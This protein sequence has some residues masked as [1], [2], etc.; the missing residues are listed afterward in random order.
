MKLNQSSI[1]WAMKH[2]FKESDTDLF[3]K[4]LEIKVIN[5]MHDK[6][7]DKLKDV[8]LGNYKWKA[9]RRFVIPKAEFSYR[10]VTQLDPIDSILFSAIVYEYGKFIESRRQ[11]INKVFSYRFSPSSDGTLY[12]NQTA[13]S[14]FWQT[15]LQKSK[16]FKYIVYL[17]IADFYNQIY[18]HVI[19]NQ[20][21][22]CGLPNQIIRSVINLL[23]SVTQTVSR[24]IPIG[25]HASHLIAEM[26]LIP[27]DESLVL[28]KIEFCRYADDIVIFCD[29]EMEAK[30]NIYTIAEILDKQQRLILQRQKTKIYTAEEF[31]RICD[32]MLK[33]NP[34]NKLEEKMIK[35]IL[36]HSSGDPYKHISMSN[37]T[38]EEKE[39]F[40][41][42]KI[43]A[44]ILEYLKEFEPNY[45]R[46]RWFYRRLTQIG[47]TH[48]IE[49]SIKNMEKLI[50]AISDVCHYL[51][52]AAGNY[53]K[54]WKIFGDDVLRLLDNDLIKSNEFFQITLL[55]LFVNNTKLNHF[56]KLIEMYRSSSENLR[57]K[58]ILAAYSMN[59]ESW[60]REL[61]EDYPKFDIWN[62]RAMLIAS[63]L[64]PAEER[65]H[66]LQHIKSSLS[67]DDILESILIEWA[68]KQN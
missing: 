52:S 45:P 7:L 67:S 29:S 65:K 59:A 28:R 8:D 11:P 44:L 18:H 37:L 26:S 17:D 46:L 21:I 62:K 60:V 42:E 24:G 10:I 3:P 1:S 4:P 50:P 27:I 25:P 61:K 16:S 14:D 35:V 66:F 56:N 2:L 13:W 30:I 38:I 43:E 39:M 55:N 63:S 36:K 20:L 5:D 64:L 15:C 19:E 41:K 22:S 49:F 68:L 54:D 32:Q 9:A 33:D 12:S 58:I 47:T 34:I 57:R 48:A 51:I 40:T 31:Q 6:V 23:G 53:D